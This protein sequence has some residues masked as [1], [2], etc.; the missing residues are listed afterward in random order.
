[1]KNILK[2]ITLASVLFGLAI[3]SKAQSSGTVTASQFVLAGTMTNLITGS[4]NVKT[5]TIVS[6][7]ASS[8]L[9]VDSFTNSTVY[10]TAAY[11]NIIYALTNAFNLATNGQYGDFFYT[12]YFGVVTTLT[13]SPGTPGQFVLVEITNSVGPQTLSLPST[14]VGTGSST[15]VTIAN[16]NQN[17][18]RGIWVTNTSATASFTITVTGNRY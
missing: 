10:T 15:P 12:N 1:M 8:G 4:F 3:E 14:V 18:Y 5:I 6:T 2:T 13:N 17:Y 16:L 7:N 11:T 9:L